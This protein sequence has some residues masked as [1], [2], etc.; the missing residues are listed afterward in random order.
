MDAR[1]DGAQRLFA[2]KES[3]VDVGTCEQLLRGHEQLLSDVKKD[4]KSLKAKGSSLCDQLVPWIQPKPRSPSSASV[5]A[6]CS[7]V[8]RSD[9]SRFRN[10]L[11]H[12]DVASGK[13]ETSVDHI[14]QTIM[15][16]ELREAHCM[17]LF[18]VQQQ[19]LKQVARRIKFEMAIREVS[20]HTHAHVHT[21]KLILTCARK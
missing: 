17:E 3:P 7:P 10:S 6:Y 20:T 5:S 4:C 8:L 12:L 16:V 2:S 1:L 14:N 18:H 9:S 21:H 15:G 13:E 19:N 11:D